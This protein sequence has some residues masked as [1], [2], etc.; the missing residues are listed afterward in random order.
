MG[1]KNL[2]FLRRLWNK[3]DGEEGKM[4]SAPKESM[5]QRLER[6]LGKSIREDIVDRFSHE[7]PRFVPFLFS[8][9]KGFS[10]G[11]RLNHFDWEAD[12]ELIGHAILSFPITPSHF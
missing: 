12:R 6:M 11:A 9:L 7:P 4:Q 2:Q 3:I 1:S 5:V 8:A 10:L